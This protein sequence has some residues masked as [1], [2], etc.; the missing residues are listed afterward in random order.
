MFTLLLA[1]SAPVKAADTFLY[2]NSSYLSAADISP[3]QGALSGVGASL[4]TTT[5]AA[6]PTAWTGYKLVIVLMPGASFSAGQ[7]N[8]L[9]SF[10][11]TGGRLVVVG[12]DGSTGGFVVEN[13]YA[14]SLLSTI[15]A[16]MSIGSTVISGTSGGCVSTNTLATDQLTGTVSRL[17]GSVA[18]PVSGGTAL[19]TYGGSSLL[20]V[21]QLAGAGAG[22]S[23]YDVVVAG[24]VHLFLGVCSGAAATGGNR[25]LWE[26]LYD[27][28]ADLDEDGV[29]AVSCGGL[30]CDDS[31]ALVGPAIAETP[32]DGIDQDCD[33]ADLTDAD[34]DG[35]DSSAVAGGDDCDDG[36]PARSPGAVERTDGVDQDC[37]GII[38]NHTA[39]YDDD[40]DGFSEEA[41]DCD[42]ED[43]TVWPGAAERPDGADQDCDGLTDEGTTAY[44]DDGDGFSE[45]AGDCDDADPAA[46][47][48]AE[49][50]PGDAIDQDCDGHDT[51][52]DADGDGLPA[53]EGDCDESN[54]AIHP[55]AEEVENGQD[56]D[57]DGLIDEGTAAAD[58]D[59][60]GYSEKEGD[61]DDADPAVNPGAEDPP[62]EDANCDG[63]RSEASDDSG[64]TDD[65]AAT[66]GRGGKGGCS[67]APG[68]SALG[69][70]GLIAA[71]Q[72]IRRRRL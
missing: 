67:H 24:D 55:G 16:G 21:G 18:S 10:V 65:S 49:D 63:I 68:P 57:C 48:G 66:V 52:V 61:C 70:L 39:A 26:N 59:D 42:D 28:C 14:N 13:G 36:D 33:G 41:G 31:S 37:D 17:Y 19:A 3:L 6:W 2:Y 46:H 45:E 38:D 44:D 58:D 5:S 11:N 32:Y 30:D 29:G 72:G 47:P 62:G 50:P 51:Y 7:A 64:H 25:S 56:D 22:R 1:L 4:D 12:D 34:G 53:E 71:A 20:S 9:K 27:T 43:D 60:D 69:L 23:P 54:A 15:G 8:A 35:Y 40:G